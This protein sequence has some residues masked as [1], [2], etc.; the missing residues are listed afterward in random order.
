MHS[1]KIVALKGG[2]IINRNILPLTTGVFI[3]G[4]S[5]KSREKKV[6]SQ[7]VP[8]GSIWYQKIISFCKILHRH[9]FNWSSAIFPMSGLSQLMHFFFLM[10]VLNDSLF[11][12]EHLKFLLVRLF[13]FCVP[14]APCPWQQ[15][16][17]S[18]P[19]GRNITGSG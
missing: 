12:P 9:R 4:Y 17:C 11:S 14:H 15:G 5:N 2:Q 13:P 10:P 3:R 6:K 8:D 1:L 19:A 7:K 16:C 18:H